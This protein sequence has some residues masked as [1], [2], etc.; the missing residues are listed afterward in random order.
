MCVA[1]Q[2]DVDGVQFIGVDDGL[3]FSADQTDFLAKVGVKDQVDFV[4]ADKDGG[5]TQKFY[6]DFGH[7]W[8][9]FDL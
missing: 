7:V 4:G 6:H 9:I 8:C 2:N 3:V 5:V 1:D